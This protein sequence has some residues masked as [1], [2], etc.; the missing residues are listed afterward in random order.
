[1]RRWLPALLAFWF[2]I[3]L[4]GVVAHDSTEHGP[5]KDLD[6]CLRAVS[7][8]ENNLMKLPPKPGVQITF[9]CEESAADLP[10]EA[11]LAAS[12]ATLE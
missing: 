9:A 11:P 4:N 6:T 12:T 8:K 5:Y 2:V 1:M 7:E 10:K 3:R